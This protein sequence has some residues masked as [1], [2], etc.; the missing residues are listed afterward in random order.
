MNA[1]RRLSILSLI[2]GVG[3][4]VFGA[5]VRITG[6]GLG[7]G[8]HWPK[9]EGHW[10]PPLD[11]P[12]LIIEVSH[13]YIAATLSVAIVALLVVALSR[14]STPGVRGRG[15]VLRAASL[16]TTLV[17]IAALF[18]AVTVK[19]ELGNKLVIVTHLAIAMTLLAVLVSAVMRAGGLGAASAGVGTASAR[20]WRGARAALALT[21]VVLVMGAFTAHVPGANASCVGFPLCRGSLVPGGTQHIQLTH[22]IL[23]FL[24]FFHLLGVAVGVTRRR[25]ASLIIRAAFA[26]FGLVLVQLVVAAALVEMQ[27]PALVRSLHQAVGTLVWVSVVILAILSRRG[28]LGVGVPARV[29]SPRPTLV[30]AE[31]AT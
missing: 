27:L 12:D 29:A 5:I 9:C 6:S 2:L 15:G 7:C 8:D 4:V 14:R 1:L 24:L 22:R 18:G 28:A 11:R 25:E 23:A 31:V 13:R 10:F 26:A 30:A 3:Q 20:T 16:A 17:V 21:F 19:L